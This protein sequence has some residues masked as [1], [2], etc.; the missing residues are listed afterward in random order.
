MESH[1]TAGRRSGSGLRQATLGL[2]SILELITYTWQ[3]TMA[4]LSQV[5]QI[6]IR[7]RVLILGIAT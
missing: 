2:A 6:H 5:M 1:C 3:D 4:D 7:D